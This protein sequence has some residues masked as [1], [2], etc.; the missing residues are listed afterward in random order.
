MLSYPNYRDLMEKADSRF[1][2]VVMASK[3]ARQ[4]NVLMSSGY[5]QGLEAL[6]PTD[7][8]LKS[9]KPLDIA[10]KEI[11]DGKITYER[12]DAKEEVK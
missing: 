1:T 4:I 7:E 10:F 3:R 6:A 8:K 12:V 9:Y 11:V 2:L 5:R